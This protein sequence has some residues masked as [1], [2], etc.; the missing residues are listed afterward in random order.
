MSSSSSSSSSKETC[1]YCRLKP[2]PSDHVAH[3]LQS[4]AQQRFKC[5]QCQKSFDFIEQVEAHFSQEHGLQADSQSGH[6]GQS[7]LNGV[8]NTQQSQL[9]VMQN[10]HAV[11]QRGHS[12]VLS[13]QGSVQNGVP[14]VVRSVVPG[15][16]QE[17]LRFLLLRERRILLPSDLRGLKCRLCK[18]IDKVISVTLTLTWKS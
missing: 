11:G 2:R 5:L 9:G 8:Q 15:G 1:L 3:L 4:H 10:D 7:G 13:G 12:S 14:S 17:K 6:C 18:V 16:Q